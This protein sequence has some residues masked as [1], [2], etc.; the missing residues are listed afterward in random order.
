M[1]APAQPPRRDA[2][3]AR[4]STLGLVAATA[5][6]A[7]AAYLRRDHRGPGAGLALDEPPSAAAREGRSR[8]RPSKTPD[9]PADRDHARGRR[10]A[11][12]RE[13]PR[14]GWIDVA[15]RVATEFSR[16]R[17]M[18]VAAGVTFYALLA[19]FPAIAAFVSL[20][21]LFFS[22]E[23]V[24]RQV[25]SLSGVIPSGAVDVIEG[26]I[27]RV[28]AQGGGALTFGFVGGLLLTLWSANS[29]M[30][31]IFD[32][33]N[34]AYDEDEERGFLALNALTLLFTLGALLIG[35]GLVA[36]VAV[37]PA[38]LAAVPLGAEIE[39]LLRWL[40]FPIA[41]VLV[42]GLL[43]LIFRYGPSRTRARWRWVLWGAG[44]GAVAFVGFSMLFTW[45][46]SNFGS[47]NATYGS[48]GAVVG[49][50][51]WIWLSTTIVLLAAELNA[52]M[53]RQTARDTT[54]APDRPLGRRGAQAADTVAPAP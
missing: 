10:A 53:E 42:T 12:P 37:M 3:P 31:A 45:Y 49:F 44:I 9:R 18:A 54:V 35:G 21:G 15:K 23:E 22:P 20:Y 4:I 13:I 38:V 40:R 50:M 52:E 27:E 25:A 8:L 33:L 2:P 19:L 47:Y 29:G 6:V 34:V 24:S 30:K 17:L 51:V 1:D 48:L 46:V 36:A 41:L 43:A 7:S 5:I 28:A 26:E 11:T 14:A 16:D 32:A 39:M